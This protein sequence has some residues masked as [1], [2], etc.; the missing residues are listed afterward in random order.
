MMVMKRFGHLVHTMLIHF[1]TALLP[2]DLVLSTLYFSTKDASFKWA[3]SYCLVGGLL[4]GIATIVTGAI[5]LMNI[6]KENKQAVGNG[7]I[8]D[9]INSL[10]TIAFTV[11]AFRAGQT[12][13]HMDEPGITLLIIKGILILT[14][15]AGNYVSR[16]L[17]YQYQLGINT[18]TS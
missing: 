7:F 9:F 16:K 10:V 2:M 3:G 6:P 17:I 8:H 4:S 13:P 12:Y 1:L 18:K 15:L 11:I 5:D 14:L